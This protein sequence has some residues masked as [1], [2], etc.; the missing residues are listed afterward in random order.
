MERLL[1]LFASTTRMQRDLGAEVG[2][3][4]YNVSVHLERARAAGDPRVIAGDE[5]RRI[6]RERQLA[7]ERQ[8]REA[9]KPALSETEAAAVAPA[10]RS[11]DPAPV[12]DPAP[13]PVPATPS[14][15]PKP[16][17]QGRDQPPGDLV[18]LPAGTVLLIDRGWVVGPTGVKKGFPLIC[19]TLSILA[20][21]A[22][23]LLPAAHIAK[24]AGV[25]SGEAVLAQLNYWKDDLA[26]IGI[27]V[28]VVG[29]SVKLRRAA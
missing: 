29:D 23:A 20:A 13:A 4:E 24:K 7:E 1:S 17:T 19:S 18:G 25:R 6:E 22:D 28:V 21:T 14:A 12:P 5:A 16:A 2:L 11:P 27:E 10:A 15:A 8:A 26:A 3:S 9:A